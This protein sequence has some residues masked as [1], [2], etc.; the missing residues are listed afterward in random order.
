MALAAA[1]F[2]ASGL[3]A[4]PVY[5]GVPGSNYRSLRNTDNIYYVG[6]SLIA[7]TASQVKINNGN[8]NRI[9]MIGTDG[10]GSFDSS[11]Y[12]QTGYFNN[13]LTNFLVGG[14]N[15]EVGGSVRNDNLWGGTGV[16]A[17]PILTTCAD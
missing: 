6:N 10:A 12:A 11:T 15:D 2:S 14:G 13:L 3:P 4:A 17:D 8:R 1:R 16:D 7:L 5:G 9:Y